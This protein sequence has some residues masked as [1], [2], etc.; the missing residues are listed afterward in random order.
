ML[1]FTCPNTI[2]VSLN[3]ALT[4]CNAFLPFNSSAVPLMVFPSI[5][6]TPHFT[7]LE[8]NSVH[9]IKHCKN[10]FGSI[11]EKHLSF[12]LLR[13]LLISSISLGFAKFFIYTTYT[14]VFDLSPILNFSI[15]KSGSFIFRRIRAILTLSFSLN[16]HF[17]LP[18]Y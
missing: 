11:Q 4:I 8:T 10:I 17:Y 15:H 3:H 2:P 16:P 13:R 18:N 7:I 12:I 1:G 5:A 6:T 14:S 9:S